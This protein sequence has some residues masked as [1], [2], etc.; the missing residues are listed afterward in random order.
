[1]LPAHSLEADG[2]FPEETVGAKTKASAKFKEKKKD[3][4]TITFSGCVFVKVILI[5]SWPCI[6]ATDTE[7]S[8][9]IP[10]A[11]RFSE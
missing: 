2:Q 9:S 3:Q 1:M 4:D 5:F 7:V 8:G 6:I 10:G 11:T